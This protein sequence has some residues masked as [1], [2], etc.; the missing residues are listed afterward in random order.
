M[1]S[2]SADIL[3]ANDPQLE[4]KE[5]Q[6]F[7]GRYGD[8]YFSSDSGLD[9]SRYVFLT[10]NHLQERWPRLNDEVF[11]IAETGF[12]TG[13]NF[14]CAWQLWNE[15]APAGAS[16]YFISFEKYPIALPDLKKALALW[17]QLQTLSKELCQQY[18]WITP[19]WHRLI[20]DN[21]RVTLTLI[22]GDIADTLPLVKA[23]VD[24]WFLDGF[25]PAKNPE[26]WQPVIFEQMAR[27]SAQS[28]TFA[29][30]TSAGIVKRGLLDASFNVNKISGYG[31]K[32]EM[33][34]GVMPNHSGNSNRPKASG[35]HAIVIGAGIAGAASAYALANRGW[36]VI[37]IDRHSE[38]AQE[39]SGNPV[40]IIYPRLTGQDTA[41]HKLAL[42][43]YLHTIRL[44]QSL[45]L[46]ANDFNA[47][48]VLQLA[49]DAQELKRCLA[50][51]ARNLP[52]TIARYVDDIQ[53]SELA[54]TALS[55][56]GLFFPAAGWV[57]PVALCKALTNNKLIHKVLNCDIQAIKKIDGRWQVWSGNQHGEQ[58]E[59]EAPVLILA[60]SN[61][62]DQFGISS[63]LSLQA[64]RGQISLL[65]H[66]AGA[67]DIKTVICTDGYVSPSANGQNALGATFSPND[68]ALD[69]RETDHLANLNMLKKM[70]PQFYQDAQ[71]EILSI[72]GRAALRAATIDYLP[73]AGPLLDHDAL[74]K[75]PP[76]YNVNASSLPWLEGVY[77]NAGHGSK[78]LTHASICAEMIAASICG[79]PAP[80][81]S[82]LLAAL[83]PNRFLLRKMGLKALVQG[84][85]AY[86]PLH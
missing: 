27:L 2:K 82:K 30:F 20:F 46:S 23:K 75:H 6:P 65:P 25:A 77:V 36:Q 84:L 14:L 39:A 62:A 80:V 81:D 22:I 34:A 61:E 43:G 79:E 53:A 17:P 32:R 1:N 15:I 10:Q 44:I 16:L 78:G 66:Q 35:Q 40:G 58:L 45:N 12:G 59:A 73:M 31:R 38:I 83:D 7:S 60:N 8:V 51:A 42:A 5:Q 54:G 64:V 24:A 52:E 74:T 85:A 21:G 76:R 57:N 9:E 48:G 37:L 4:W 69:V 33:L 18:Q 50:V 29:T 13:L 63:N 86:P 19:G 26:M 47:C 70:A 41:M 67:K 56:P 72:S 55:Q 3:Q 11:T 68:I 71:T 28:S 49:F